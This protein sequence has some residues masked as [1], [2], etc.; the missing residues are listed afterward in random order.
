MRSTVVFQFE[1]Y[2]SRFSEKLKKNQQQTGGFFFWFLGDLG[3]EVGGGGET[4]KTYAV[5]GSPGFAENRFLIALLFSAY[6]RNHLVV[7]NTIH[8]YFPTT[9]VTKPRSVRPSR[10]YELLIEI[11]FQKVYIFPLIVYSK[12]NP[13]TRTE[14]DLIIQLFYKLQYARSYCHRCVQV[15]VIL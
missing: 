1:E 7:Y 12:C 13:V 8:L 6:K 14:S 3:Y 2:L 4:T 10:S 11:S 15:N 5:T 9:A